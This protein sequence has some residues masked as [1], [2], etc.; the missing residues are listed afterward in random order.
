MAVLVVVG[1]TALG[2]DGSGDDGAAARQPAREARLASDRFDARRA[3]AELARQ[4]RSGPR[5][6]GSA[7]SRALAD[8]LRRRLPRG[9]FEPVAGGLRNVVGSLPGRRPAIVL[10]A[11]Y[12]TKDLPDFVG[13]NDGASGTAAVLELARGL[14]RAKRPANARELR[15][16]FF[17]GEESPDDERDFYSS[18]LRGSRAYAARHA[19]EIGTL[20]LLDFVGDKQ[21]EIRREEG[22][23][24]GL[25]AELRAAARRMGAQRS[26]PSGSTGEVLDDHTPF[27]R[28]GVTAIDLI[29][30]DF[31]CFHKS[32]DDLSAV[33]AASLDRVGETVFELV[34]FLDSQGRLR[35]R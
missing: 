24:P 21:L 31:P 4:V 11:H 20:I 26:F 32:C 23:D 8:R 17:D 2:S 12:D 33:S 9:R 29:D 27:A 14:R 13:A 6:A 35:Q 3:F 28:R 34:R 22:S 15:F 10:A 5:P 1:V 19:R 16:V 30:F 25:W 7:T 18:G